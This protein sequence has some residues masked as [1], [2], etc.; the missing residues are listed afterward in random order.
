[1]AGIVKDGIV[2][3]IRKQLKD[4]FDAEML[5]PGPLAPESAVAYGYLRKSL[6]FE[7]L[8]EP[9]IGPL[10][11]AGGKKRVAA[12]GVNHDTTYPDAQRALRQVTVW[13]LGESGHFVLEFAVKGGRD[14]LVLAMIPPRDTLAG[15]W[16]AAQAAMETP[17]GGDAGSR[18]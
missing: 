16:H 17:P 10:A 11:F 18:R 15:T 1:M 14:R 5:D 12:F 13:R 2:P 6:P 3:I 4:R 8:F 7:I 9:R